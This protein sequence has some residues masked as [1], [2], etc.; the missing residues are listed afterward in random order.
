M[1]GKGAVLFLFNVVTVM[2]ESTTP[3]QSISQTEYHHDDVHSCN[4]ML[5]N[6]FSNL[7]RNS[8]T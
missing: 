2:G 1:L 8:Q 3:D 7:T 4:C 6:M 5:E